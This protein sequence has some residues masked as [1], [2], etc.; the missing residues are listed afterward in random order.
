MYRSPLAMK[1]KRA[2]SSMAAA[3]MGKLKAHRSEGGKELGGP[4]YSLSM[5][6][7]VLDTPG[8]LGMLMSTISGAGDTTGI[9][10]DCCPL[11]A[12]GRVHGDG[13]GY[14]THLDHVPFGDDVCI[15]RPERRLT[16]NADDA[17]EEGFCVRPLADS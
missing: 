15:F 6:P 8:I 16:V 2:P 14:S 13:D 3:A 4:A 5:H 12:L 7:D 11:L 17:A 1:L 10:G 9:G